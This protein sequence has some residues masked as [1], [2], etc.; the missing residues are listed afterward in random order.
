MKKLMIA[1]MATACAV[2]V[3][4]AS[5]DWSTSTTGKVFLPGSTTT[6][7]ASGTAYIFDSAAYTQQAV[8]TAF[9]ETGVD[10]SKSL[11]NKAV[12]D[13]KISATKGEAFTWGS[14]GDTLNAY[15]AIVNGDNI[16]ISDIV[17]GDASD[18]GYTS[19]SFKLKDQSQAALSTSTSFSAGGW[20]TAAA[21]P[22]PE[23]TSGLLMLLG[24]A[25]LALR[26]RR[27]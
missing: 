19:L 16:F 27:A 21:A 10:F 8:L 25:G 23:P 26:R 2:A 13:G 9:A 5:F 15:V 18:V 1:V 17:S 20:Y 4:A 22:V 11:G 3:N 6:Y 12:S 7:L 24:M 14:A